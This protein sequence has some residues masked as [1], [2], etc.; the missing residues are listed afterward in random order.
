MFNEHQCHFRTYFRFEMLT[1]KHLK[2]YK[3]HTALVKT[4][5]LL[6]FMNV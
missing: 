6:I 2:K 5:T 3:Y 4:G 1:G